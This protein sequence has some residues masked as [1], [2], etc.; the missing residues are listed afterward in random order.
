M[1]HL[2]GARETIVGASTGSALDVSQKTH[3]PHL[4]QHSP[5]PG[6][7]SQYKKRE[8]THLKVQNQLRPDTQGF[9]S[10]NVGADLTPEKAVT[11]SDQ[12]GSAT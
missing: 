2:S 9:C 11:A 3:K 8:N 6:Q 4:P 12:R 5:S 7:G 10:S 1:L